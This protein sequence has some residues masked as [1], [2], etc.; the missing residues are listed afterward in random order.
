MPWARLHNGGWGRK[1]FFGSRFFGWPNY[2][3]PPPIHMS[4]KPPKGSSRFSLE[5]NCF[6][7]LHQHLRMRWNNHFMLLKCLSPLRCA[8]CSMPRLK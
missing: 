2:P 6:F 1:K 8:T 5:L 7:Y 3:P 4:T